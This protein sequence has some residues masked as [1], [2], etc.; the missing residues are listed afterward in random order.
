MS[1]SDTPK[2]HQV[3]TDPVVYGNYCYKFTFFRKYTIYTLFT[4]ELFSQWKLT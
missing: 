4:S 1:D 3:N 2:S